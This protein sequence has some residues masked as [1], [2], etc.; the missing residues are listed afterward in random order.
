MEQVL[1]KCLTPTTDMIIQ[2]I[3]I[4]NAHINTNH[5]DFVGSADTL[6]NIFSNGEAGERE[7]GEE[8]ELEV[9]HRSLVGKSEAS[10]SKSVLMNPS[11]KSKKASAV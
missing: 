2:L 5:P 4:E 11:N 7:E 9:K 8:S 6:L 10:L 1:D 3:E